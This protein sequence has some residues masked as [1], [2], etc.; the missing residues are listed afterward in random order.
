MLERKFGEKLKLNKRGM[1]YENQSKTVRVFLFCEN[2][3]KESEDYEENG[4]YKIF[5]KRC[6]WGVF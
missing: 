1:K 2:I 4:K 3:E 6:D 5:C